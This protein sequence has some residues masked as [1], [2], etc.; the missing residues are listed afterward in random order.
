MLLSSGWW[1]GEL[2]CVRSLRHEVEWTGKVLV[3]EN[4]LLDRIRDNLS[5]DERPVAG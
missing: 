2:V 3:L 4:T 1:W 5:E